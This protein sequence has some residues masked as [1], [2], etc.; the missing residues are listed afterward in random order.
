MKS[1]RQFLLSASS[2]SAASVL[3]AFAQN[4]QNPHFNVDISP[5]LNTLTGGKPILPGRVRL[6]LPILVENGQSVTVRVDVPD[7]AAGDVRSLHIF[8]PRN[9]RPAVASFFFGPKAG[10]P[11]IVTRIRLGGTQTVQVVAAF[12]DGTWRSASLPVEVTSSACL[13]AASL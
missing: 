10:K 4:V 9:P 7:A 2:L 12:A 1:R 3:P 5:L 11:D 8:A 6:D 13:D